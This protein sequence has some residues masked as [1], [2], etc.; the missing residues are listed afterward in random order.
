MLGVSDPEK[1]DLFQNIDL[2]Y[3]FA[4]RRCACSVAARIEEEGNLYARDGSYDS[5]LWP[6]IIHAE[7]APVYRPVYSSK[8]GTTDVAYV[9]MEA[10]SSA[11]PDE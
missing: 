1:A 10:A 5:N 8:L 2:A 7:H 11:K 4:E 6:M 3:F 9:L